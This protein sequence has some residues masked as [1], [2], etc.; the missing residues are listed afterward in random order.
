V[1][2]WTYAVQGGTTT[3]TVPAGVTSLALEALGAR[4]GQ[5]SF[6]NNGG[7]AIGTYA[8][9]SG[10]V[11]TVFCGANLAGDQSTTTITVPVK[12]RLISATSGWDDTTDGNAGMGY[13][14][15]PTYLTA[16]QTTLGYNAGGGTINI[17]YAGGGAT[18]VG[19]AALSQSSVL[20]SVGVKTKVATS[21]L[22]QTSVLAAAAVKAKVAT[23]PL[24]QS[25]VLGAT[26]ALVGSAPLS[27]T[28]ALGATGVQK[29]AIIGMAALSQ[30]STLGV[31]GIRAAVGTVALSQ[32]STLGATGTKS[33]T[34][35]ATAPL[36]Q[37]SVM[38]SAGAIISDRVTRSWAWPLDAAWIV[39]IS[40]NT[41]TVEA[42]GPSG[43]DV[44]GDV[45]ESYGGGGGYVKGDM[46]VTPG[47]TIGITTG[48]QGWSGT[49]S[50]GNGT[51]T[52]VTRNGGPVGV[53]GQGGTGGDQDTDGVDGSWSY[54]DSTNITNV[55]GINGLWHGTGKISITYLPPP[56]IVALSQD[57]SLGIMASGPGTAVAVAALS[58]ASVLGAYFIPGLAALTDGWDRTD[59]ALLS[60]W[61]SYISPPEQFK[62]SNHHLQS[63]QGLITDVSV[64]L[65]TTNDN[66]SEIKAADSN[67]GWVPSV[68]CRCSVLGASDL[69]TGACYVWSSVGIGH[70]QLQRKEAFSATRTSIGPLITIPDLNGG[71]VIR[72]EAIGTTIIGYVNGE[73]VSVVNDSVVTTGKYVGIRSDTS[74]GGYVCDGWAGGDVVPPSGPAGAWAAL[75]QDSVLGPTAIIGMLALAASTLGQDS[76][77]IAAPGTGLASVSMSQDN[78]LSPGGV[79]E[80]I[81][82][83]A[84]IQTS[85]LEA[86]GIQIAPVTGDVALIQPSA[87]GADAVPDSTVGWSQDSV[88]V[89]GGVRLAPAVIVLVQSS[90]LTSTPLD[91]NIAAVAMSQANTIGLVGFET[92]IVAAVLSQSS[93][94]TMV[95]VRAVDATSALIQITVMTTASVRVA[96]AVVA[97]SQ[98]SIIVMVGFEVLVSTSVLVQASSMGATGD[99]AVV[100]VAALSQASIL[101]SAVLRAAVATVGLNQASVLVTASAGMASAVVALVQSSSMVATAFEVLVVVIA[102]AQGSVLGSVGVR[103]ASPVV[104]LSQAAV[105]ISAGIIE[106]WRLVSLSQ[107]S[108]LAVLP[109][110]VMPAS[111]ALTQS[112]TLAAIAMGVLVAVQ[113][114]SQASVLAVAGVRVALPV[115][116]M[117]QASVLSLVGLEILL[118]AVSMT[119][120]SA[121]GVAGYIGVIYAGLAVFAQASSLGAVGVIQ[122]SLVVTLAQGSVLGAIALEALI[123]GAALSQLSVLSVGAII[124]RLAV[125]ALSV[126]SM[127]SSVA[128]IS[129]LAAV[130]MSQPSTLVVVAVRA[131]VVT[132]A[133]VQNSVA[134]IGGIREKVA[135][136]TLVQATVLAALAGGVVH[137]ASVVMSQPSV[138]LGVGVQRTYAAAA[139]IALS[140]LQADAVA[141]S[142]FV[143]WV[144]PVG[145]GVDHRM[146]SDVMVARLSSATVGSASGES[147]VESDAGTAEVN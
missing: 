56:V 15:G 14:D 96:V 44:G 9:T 132:A 112:S 101:V 141:A 76:V 66:Y 27:Q 19:T 34:A 18:A 37:S 125:A 121:V 45:Y 87:I 115:V 95:V 114:M 38:G 52:I 28:S 134:T 32:S 123:V 99:R 90:L 113:A 91:T 124:I 105:L 104:A 86:I 23:A 135:I 6:F 4:G 117:S 40:V 131:A 80:V 42:W 1:T 8:C 41:I 118:A 84:F 61:I 109:F 116:A 69:T 3:F 16:T 33:S 60:P 20:G 127:L 83:K 43:G 146:P 139:L 30:S 22:S 58:Q 119:Q 2:I 138:L 111:V 78:V 63:G 17:T 93:V 51:S 77:L 98:A 50:S 140:I 54:I 79:R 35:V 24:S 107:S 92:R 13:I 137:A 126:D 5:G 67:V 62:I 81:A 72:I 102:L 26:N 68:I 73:A 57:S 144:T 21:A 75:L 147:V 82:S 25:S 120:G 49:S 31:V 55:S 10:E 100:M 130:V 71:G 143:S 85:S 110:G 64:Q 48:Q 133:L 74:S 145:S 46:S 53:T 12:G 106:G 29:S 97:L 122:S 59:G 88:L 70:M 136:A 94:M 39:P 47:D 142:S 103:T 36:S 108:V 89:V 128:I 129:R 65:V 7:R 11:V